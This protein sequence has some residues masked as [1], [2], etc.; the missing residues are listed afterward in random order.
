MLTI[1]TILLRLLLAGALGFLIG[2]E[3]EVRGRPA[4]LRTNIIVTGSAALLMILS[5]E[6][7]QLF[8]TSDALGVIR[9]DPGR[10]AS[11][12]VAGMGFLGAGAI[13]QGRGSV[14][15][16]TSAASLWTAN[17]IGL[18]VGAGFYIPAIATTFL[19]ILALLPFSWLMR[20]IPK[21]NDIRILLHFESCRDRIDELRLILHEYK[22]RIMY[23]Q[24]DCDF[25]NP[26]SVYE[27]GLRMRNKKSWP[28]LQR[29]LRRL[30]D[31]TK[32]SWK[33]GMV[34]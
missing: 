19:V 13:I 10:I 7:H 25:D 21:D 16:L 4:G 8:S 5:I 29:S 18:A 27:I 11:Y 3:R 6:L 30:E 20:L 12:A 24:F 23:I 31:L 14:Q 17:A 15:G 34:I 2:L 1:E 33:E 32:I 26:G 9:L 28:E 22:A